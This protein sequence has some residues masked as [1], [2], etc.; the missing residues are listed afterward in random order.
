MPMTNR[1]QA[2]PDWCTAPNPLDARPGT[3]A[4]Q[5]ALLLSDSSAKNRKQ[6][7]EA[8]KQSPGAATLP[9]CRHPSSMPAA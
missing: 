7:L 4:M 1:V 9:G 3:S 5:A 6:S 2:G 8:G